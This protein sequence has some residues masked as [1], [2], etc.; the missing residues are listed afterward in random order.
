MQLLHVGWVVATLTLLGLVVYVGLGATLPGF[1]L[2][3]A[4]GNA[5]ETVTLQ[6]EL[7]VLSES[8]KEMRRLSESV[9][10][11]AVESVGL[12]ERRTY[13]P[14]VDCLFIA[15]AGGSKLRYRIGRSLLRLL[16]AHFYMV[17]MDPSAG[18]GEVRYV[19]RARTILLGGKETVTPG[20]ID[21]TIAGLRLIR[22]R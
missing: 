5:S 8:V 11:A 21:S 20:M 22:E 13:E 14:A 12:T 7:R 16:P 6:G 3:V 19:E 2:R 9:K 15:I 4:E 17:G 10:A 18:A 1:S